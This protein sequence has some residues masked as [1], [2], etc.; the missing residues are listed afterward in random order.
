MSPS[1]ADFFSSLFPVIPRSAAVMAAERSLLLCHIYAAKPMRMRATTV[2][3]VLKPIFTP[4]PTPDRLPRLIIELIVVLDCSDD[5]VVELGITGTKGAGNSD[6]VEF[7]ISDN[8]FGLVTVL[9]SMFAQPIA[10]KDVNSC[11]V[12]Y[13]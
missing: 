7:A 8:D 10:P 5:D 9:C 6:L 11:E 13:V 4:R 3:A 1:L 2:T 12:T